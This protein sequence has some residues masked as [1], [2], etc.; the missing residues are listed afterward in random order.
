VQKGHCAGSTSALRARTPGG[1]AAAVSDRSDGCDNTG[2][3]VAPGVYFWRLKSE[4]TTIT[5]KA[6]KID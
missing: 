6:I 4:T 2:R 1:L 3:R 5:R